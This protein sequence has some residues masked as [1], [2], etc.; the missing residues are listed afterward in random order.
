M[1]VSA[2]LRRVLH[3]T[4]VALGWLGLAFGAVA[5]IGWLPGRDVAEAPEPAPDGPPP[6][7]PDRQG[8]VRLSREEEQAWAELHD[9]W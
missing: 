7:H 8:V 1:S 5:P 9:T 4:G 3:R 2:R 6:G